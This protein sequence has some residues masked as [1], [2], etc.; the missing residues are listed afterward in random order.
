MKLTERQQLAAI[1]IGAGLALVSLWRFLLVPQQRAR[2]QLEAD[3]RAMARSLSDRNLLQEEAPL[4]NQLYDEEHRIRELS[5]QWRQ[6]AERLTG[7]PDHH[8]LDQTDVARIDYK[9]ALFDVRQRLRAKSDEIGI[10][11]PHALGME[12]AITTDED[13]RTRMLQLRAAER[14]TELA[15]NLRIAEIQ[16]IEPLPPIRHTLGERN[17]PYMEEYPVRMVLHG[18]MDSLHALFEASLKPEHVFSLRRVRIDRGPASAATDQL[19]IDIVLSALFFLRDA[20]QLASVT[21][22]APLRRIPW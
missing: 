16:H 18:P 20:D 7:F 10:P 12:E 21:E 19:Q 4:R 13:T 15:L 14:L 8:N 2:A 17:T 5:Q 6:T 1:I 11:L 3:I 9:A 22:R